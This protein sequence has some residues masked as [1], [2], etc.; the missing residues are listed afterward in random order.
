[1][2]PFIH[3]AL[4]LNVTNEMVVV[5]RIL[6]WDEKVVKILVGGRGQPIPT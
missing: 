4:C 2:S 6:K 1:M 3:I 5:K